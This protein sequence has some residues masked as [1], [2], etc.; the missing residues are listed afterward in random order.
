LGTLTA[1]QMVYGKNTGTT[2]TFYACG[3]GVNDCSCVPS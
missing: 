1:G 2:D 3:P